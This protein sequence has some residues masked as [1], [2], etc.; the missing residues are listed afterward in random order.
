LQGELNGALF[1]S[2]EAAVT[3]ACAAGKAV[4]FP[5]GTYVVTTGMQACSSLKIR[6]VA[7]NVVAGASST[8][9]QAA[10]GATIWMFSSPTADCTGAGAPIAACSASGPANAQNNVSIENVTFDMSL[11]PQ[12]LG[13]IRHKGMGWAHYSNVSIYTDNNPNPAMTL[14]GGNFTLNN[15][16]YYLQADN[17]IMYNKATG[18]T[19]T[20]T[21]LL[22]TNCGVTNN[23]STPTC[24][25]TASSN[26]NQSV[27]NGGFI[28]RFGTNIECDAGGNNI[29][30]GTD[31]SN[32]FVYGFHGTTQA[33]GACSSNHLTNNR[34]EEL[35]VPS[36]TGVKFEVGAIGNTVQNP[37]NSGSYNWYIDLNSPVANTCDHCLLGIPANFQYGSVHAQPANFINEGINM[38][39]SMLDGWKSGFFSV[40]GE[41]ES[42]GPL[43][44]GS[45]ADST[46]YAKIQYSGS[47]GVVLTLPGVTGQILSTN[48]TID[49]TPQGLASPGVTYS[50]QFFKFSSSYDTG[51]VQ[52]SYY[53]SGLTTTGSAGDT[54]IVSGYNGGGTGATGTLTLSGTNTV[55]SGTPIIMT[56]PGSGYTSLPTSASASAGT[57]SSC[58]GTLVLTSVTGATD[59]YQ[60]RSTPTANTANPNTVLTIT[61]GGSPGL[62]F[63]EPIN[64]NWLYF[65]NTAA[66]SG[67]NV[68]GNT[69]QY[70]S[71]AWNG[72]VSA[73]DIWTI[74]PV[75]AAGTNP[76][77]T[78]TF[79]H[80]GPG[81]GSVSV[82]N[83]V[84][85]GLTAGTAPICPNG[86][87]GTLTTSGCTATTGTGL[88]GM[89]AGQVPIAAS[90]AS[91]TSSIPLGNSGNDIPQL[92]SGLL[93]PSVIPDNTANAGG[94]AG[95][96]LGTMWYQSA[97]D[98]TAAIAPNTSVTILCL[99]Q[100]GDGVNSAAPVWG[101]CAGST[102]VAFSTITGS[103][104]TSAAMLVGTGASLGPTG[105]GTVNANQVNGAS[106][107]TS[108]TIVGTNSSG[109]IIDA[110]SATLTN[111]TSG[112]AATATVATAL[113]A[114]PTNCSAGQAPRG[115][116][117][118]GVAQNCTIYIQTICSGTIALNTTAIPL[119]SSFDNTATC[120]GLLTS[121][122][123][124][125]DFA[126]NPTAVTGYDVA[127]PTLTIYKYPAANTIH[128]VQGN[129]ANNPGTITPGA[130]TVNYHVFR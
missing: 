26:S 16:N 109:Q 52:N 65:N 60:L 38:I 101:A 59:A 62:H 39:P 86:P 102:A 118:S 106:V 124:Q 24:T 70:Y 36:S 83:L 48:Q 84:D 13:A 17:V 7:P 82:P 18:G 44:L 4:Y 87:N 80:S 3:A 34:F 73:P 104:N 114:S 1:A 14:D 125:I 115:I 35:S 71:N 54:C 56:A 19:G 92:S 105:T 33:H 31:L 51:G 122:N 113:A 96:T 77:S 11:D 78:W 129:N 37:Y 75:L 79:A 99:T 121:D 119:G 5:S 28:N 103:T 116:N 47:A 25:S 41:L 57:A 94:L 130:M 50:S 107:P 76:Q 63:V 123:I 40:R 110:S 98:I 117:A 112:N 22:I 97:P 88:S 12:A 6:G 30:N 58:S 67:A 128:V 9:F 61:A 42:T 55:A 89:T 93:N 15:G 27:W 66:T 127:G 108:K 126:S 90:A 20:G 32:F 100:Q 2:P 53:T 49:L 43:V 72:S 45:T 111:N 10:S 29:F 8:V 95:G 91:V 46:S 85:T 21:G 64:L 74:S 81:N 69:F 23:P 68:S 120:T